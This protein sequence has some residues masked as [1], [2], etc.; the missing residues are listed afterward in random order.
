MAVLLDKLSQRG[1][2]RLGGGNVST[3]AA[4]QAS[5]PLPSIAGG[6]NRAPARNLTTTPISSR[7]AQRPQRG[8]VG[9]LPQFAGTQQ[10]FVA[11]LPTNVQLQGIQDIIGG[12]ASGSTVIDNF[13]KGQS[14]RGKNP[15]QIRQSFVEQQKS[16]ASPLVL[17]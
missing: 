7:I 6:N 3:P 11:D 17:S 12:K 8:T 9:S 16:S 10:R 2:Q 14:A 15:E 13:V 4:L 5:S 1:T